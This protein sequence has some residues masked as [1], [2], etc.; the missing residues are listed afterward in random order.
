MRGSPWW[1]ISWTITS[2]LFLPSL[3]P[4]SLVQLIVS[5][6]DWCLV[7]VWYILHHL[8]L[9][10]NFFPILPQSLSPSASNHIE[11]F[12]NQIS[13]T[14]LKFSW[15]W[16]YAHAYEYIFPLLRGNQKK[17]IWIILEIN[18]AVLFDVWCAKFDKKCNCYTP[19]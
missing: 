7:W 10:A 6:C 4:Q 18:G 1:N 11:Y 12:T 8:R 9:R 15:K 3:C 2:L 19:N 5:V 16:Q 14:E 13:V 17:E